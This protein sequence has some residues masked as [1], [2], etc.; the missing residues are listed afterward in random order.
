M[1]ETKLQ[2][3]DAGYRTVQTVAGPSHTVTNTRETNAGFLTELAFC[4]G[5]LK[6]PV[7]GLSRPQKIGPVAK[8]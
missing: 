2:C 1:G 3:R 7:V 8:L 5:F 6:V 4:G